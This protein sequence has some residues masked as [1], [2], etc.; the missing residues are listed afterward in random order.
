MEGQSV[1]DVIG[2]GEWHR[3]RDRT[4]IDE[5]RRLPQTRQVNYFF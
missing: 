5:R 4:H 2:I 1:D 3:L